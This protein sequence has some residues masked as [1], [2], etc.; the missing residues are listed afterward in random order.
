MLI[1]FTGNY[2]V[3]L[4]CLVLVLVHYNIIFRIKFGKYAAEG[5]RFFFEMQTMFPRIK[6]YP[7]FGGEFLFLSKSATAHFL[8]VI[9]STLPT[10][11]PALPH[12]FSVHTSKQMRR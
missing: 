12:L 9:I 3:S 6:Y 11:R 4:F 5:G 8:G 10:E 2:S 1:I 7:F